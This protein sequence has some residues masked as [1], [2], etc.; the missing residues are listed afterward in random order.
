MDVVFLLLLHG[1]WASLI[2]DGEMD[3]VI[4]HYTIWL[5]L[6]QSVTTKQ[7]YFLYNNWGSANFDCTIK[8]FPLLIYLNLLH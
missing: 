2:T 7:V 6:F 1:F 3:C 8:I 4:T 5:L